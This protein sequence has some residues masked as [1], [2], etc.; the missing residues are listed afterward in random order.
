[1]PRLISILQFIIIIFFLFLFFINNNYLFELKNLPVLF[2]ILYF[3]IFIFFKIKNIFFISVMLL[4]DIVFV[5]WSIYIFNNEYFIFFYF[6][7]I[8]FVRFN[9]NFKNSLLIFLFT[10]ISFYSVLII[11]ILHNKILD[12]NL[13]IQQFFIK[14]VIFLIAFY[15]INELIKKVEYKDIEVSE[16]KREINI[17]N[18][19][20][21]ALSH[22]LRTPL[23]MIKSSVDIILDGKPGKINT[24]Q[25]NFLNIISNNIFRLINLV[26]DILLLI[27]IESS[28]LKLDLKTVDIKALIKEIVNN[29]KPI[30]S[31]KKQILKY[32]HPKIIS[33]AIA[34]KKWLQ[35]VMINL[36]NN[37]SKH[38]EGDGIIF[39]ALKENEQCVLI[40]VSDNGIG[41]DDK[42]KKELLNDND[43]SF[44]NMNIIKDGYGLGLSIVKNIVEKHN[45]KIYMGS[46]Y[47]LGTTFSF[48][49]PKKEGAYS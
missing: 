22:E 19:I 18:N 28:W 1:M 21:T 36:I 45:G 31:Q 38:L 33:K 11:N 37:A 41:I 26:E 4:F 40:S 24:E 49:L 2:Y 10:F 39:V 13:L 23:T 25:K 48:T 12:Y 42:K 43:S 30:I 29:M 3:I 20:L 7:I 46:I 47:G 17:K 34:D 9:N 35:H 14:P 8:L 16:L 27:K 5:T 32:S 15:V 44:E 6:L